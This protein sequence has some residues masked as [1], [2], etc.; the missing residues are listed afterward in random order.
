MINHERLLK[1]FITLLEINS[2]S[3]KEGE[4]ADVISRELRD[5]GCEVQFDSA[6]QALGGEIGNIIATL[7]PTAPDGRN[8]LLCSHMD[9]VQP[10]DGIRVIQKDGI[11]RQE[12]APVLGADDKAGVAAIIE[13]IRSVVESGQPHGQIQVAILI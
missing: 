12:G 3:R 10:T 7:K 6:G 1:S 5:L 11:I 9:T 4:V 13:G 8:I 2:P